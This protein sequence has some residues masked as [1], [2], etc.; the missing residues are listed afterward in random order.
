[1]RSLWLPARRAFLRWH[2]AGRGRPVVFLPGLGVPAAA[3]FLEAA[4]DPA[5]A[6]RRALLVDPPGSGPSD[7]PDPP[8]ETLAAH[9]ADLAALLDHLALG[10]VPVVGHSFGGSLAVALAAARPD[11]VAALVLAEA[12]LAPGGGRLSCRIARET[13]AAWVARGHAAL[14]AR[15]RA[16]GAAGDAEAA[17]VAGAM[18]RMDAAALHAAAAALIAP[19]LDL[20]TAF[21]AFPGPRHFV[22]GARRRPGRAEDATPDT[23][24]PAALAARGVACHTVPGAGH[25]MMRDNPAGFAAALAAALGPA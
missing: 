13:R 12:N 18:A 10:P 11:L 2:E 22:Y 8:H 4:T 1:M 15:Q 20:M 17:F 9:A 21:A 19:D 25:L 23:P 14:V 3:A 24:D 5:L 7:A 6:G 16:R